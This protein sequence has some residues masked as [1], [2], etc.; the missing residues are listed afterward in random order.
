VLAEA[1]EGNDLGLLL[2]IRIDGREDNM[3]TKNS[4]IR[5]NHEILAEVKS[6]DEQIRALEDKKHVILIHKDIHISDSLHVCLAPSH[7]E[8]DKVA[9]EI[10]FKQGCTILQEEEIIK[11]YQYLER[12]IIK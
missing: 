9:I 3:T 8:K 7:V 12:L 4:K 10:F 11:L 2:T 6:I 5:V 1:S